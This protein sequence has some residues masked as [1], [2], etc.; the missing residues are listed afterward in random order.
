[1]MDFELFLGQVALNYGL[2]SV[3]ELLMFG[4]LFSYVR[5]KVVWNPQT[6]HKI[7]KM[8]IELES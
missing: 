4:S 2:V 7:S 1:M 6:V 5:Q 3:R 8:S